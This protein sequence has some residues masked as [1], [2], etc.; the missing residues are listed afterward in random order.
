MNTVE[1]GKIRLR[2]CAF[3][4]EH[5]CQDLLFLFFF[6][7]NEDIFIQEVRLISRA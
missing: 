5:D 4:S 1:E 6:C 3:T 2:F 7:G